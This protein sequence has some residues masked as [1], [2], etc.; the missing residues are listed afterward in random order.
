[1]I[2]NLYALSPSLQV[3]NPYQ[4]HLYNNGMQSAGTMRYNV[5]SNV[6]E[7]YD[8]ANWQVVSQDASVGL[9]TDAEKAIEW[10]KEKMQEEVL[11]KA[12]M[13]KYP[14]LKD[15]YEQFKIIEALV[16]EDDKLAEATASV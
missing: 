2:K 16:N 12:K 5:N 10:V 1:M 11:L 4:P 3:T 8:G 15:A 13:E 14:A 9:S 6:V 7:V